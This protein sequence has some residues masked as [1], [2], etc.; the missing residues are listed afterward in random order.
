MKKI[1]TW[2]AID[3]DGEPAGTYATYSGGPYVDVYA[4]REQVMD[5]INVHD[6]ETGRNL[7][8]AAVDIVVRSVYAM[9]IAADVRDGHIDPR[10][11]FM[12]VDVLR[13]LAIDARHYALGRYEVTVDADVREGFA[14]DAD[15]LRTLATR[16]GQVMSSSDDEDGLAS[17]A[18]SIA[19]AAE[20]TTRGDTA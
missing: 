9:D 15:L 17:L 5:T 3:A 12:Y 6:Y 11:D 20:A 2:Y 10:E 8:P 14:G 19:E 13:D 16:A 1:T 4:G 7:A 18:E